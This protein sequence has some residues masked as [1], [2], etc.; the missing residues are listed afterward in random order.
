M[1]FA[2][3]LLSIIRATFLARI[4]RDTYRA[5]IALISKREILYC[6]LAFLHPFD[7]IF[8]SKRSCCF[9]LGQSI[10]RSSFAWS[11]CRE[12]AVDRP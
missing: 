7:Q 8:L 3:D 11:A 6:R 1:R 9:H 5:I 4:S 12:S 2:I 10:D